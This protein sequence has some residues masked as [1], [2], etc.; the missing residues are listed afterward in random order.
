PSERLELLER[1]GH[2]AELSG[3]LADAVR[4]WGEAAGGWREIGDL[5]RAAA[6]ERRLATIHEME[7]GWEQALA[8]H[9][10]AAD[11]F[12]ASGLP[13]EAAAERLAVVSHLRSAASYTAALPLLE[14]I[15]REAEQ[16]A[17]PDLTAR[18]LGH[19]GSA[20]ARLGQYEAG[21]ALIR[22]G[23]S[24]ALKHN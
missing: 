5:R 17:R 2:C 20:R 15:Y 18:A 10:S 13:G 11:G 22:D 3:D 24:L 12:S 16:A 14:T 7:G 8:A 1:L 21:L 6:A 23:L 19:E 4:A 9:M